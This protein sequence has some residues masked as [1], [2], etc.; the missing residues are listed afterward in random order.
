MLVMPTVRKIMNKIIVLWSV[1][2]LL[3][4][5]NIKQN[6]R[7]TPN[8]NKKNHTHQTTRGYEY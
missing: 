2:S 3:E 1:L 7:R 4:T 5:K 8:N 6:K